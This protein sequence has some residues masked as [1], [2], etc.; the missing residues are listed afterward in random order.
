MTTFAKARASRAGRLFVLVLA[1]GAAGGLAGSASAQESAGCRQAGQIVAEVSRL[2]AGGQPDHASLLN[3]LATARDLCPSFG[4]A[5]KYSACSARALGQEAKARVY[6]DRAVLNG[7]ADV[8]CG[9]TGGAG[10]TPSAL[11]RLGP[12]RNKDALVVG[13]GTFKDPRIPKLRYTAK[14]ASDFRDY[15]IDPKGGRFD[16]KRVEYLV[17]EDATREGILKALQRIFLRSQ[18]QDLLVVYVS[19]HGSPREGA[20]GLQGVGYIV[21][22]DTAFD[23]LFVDALEFQSFSEKVSLIQARRK[24][25]FLDTCYSGQALRSGAKNLAITPLGVS[26]ETAKLFTSAEGS[27]LITSSDSN[28]ESWESDKLQNSFFTYYLLAALRQG[29]DPPTLKEV[30]ANLARKVSAAALEEKRARQSPQLHPVTGPADLR[31][32]APPLPGSPPASP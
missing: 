6:A 19:S 17:D 28:E 31:I 4:E 25:T 18:E 21:T 24:V 30:F 3:R 7:V 5:W 22:Y 9:E 11:A 12:I 1:L 8:N 23:N 26:S 29:G 2:Y 10:Q 15:L 14:D 13:I 20:L 27:Y 16:P 32:G